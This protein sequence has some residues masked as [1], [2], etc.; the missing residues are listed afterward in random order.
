ME[1]DDKWKM[2]NVITEEKRIIKI[3]I[4]MNGLNLE[5]IIERK[6]ILSCRN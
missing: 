6:P 1:R 5:E 2:K 4:K 3:Y